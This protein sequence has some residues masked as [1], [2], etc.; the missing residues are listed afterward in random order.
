MREKAMR[1]ITFS[2]EVP[3][4]PVYHSR[5]CLSTLHWTFIR[6]SHQIFRNGGF[7][8][9]RTAWGHRVDRGHRTTR[10]TNVK[11]FGTTTTAYQD[12]LCSHP[13]LGGK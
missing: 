3:K 12:N 9:V 13:M 5:A 6:C 10:Q 4:N 11:P 1:P 8:G 2:A 7:R